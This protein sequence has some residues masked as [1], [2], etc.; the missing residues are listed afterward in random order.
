MTPVSMSY[1]HLAPAS[2]NSRLRAV[3][4]LDR[5]EENMDRMHG[6]LKPGTLMAAVIKADGYGHGAVPIGRLLDKKPYLW[7]FAVA[8]PEEAL[9]LKAAGITKPVMLLGY[10]FPESFEDLILND[11]RLTV[12]DEATAACLNETA[13]KMDRPCFIHIAVDTGMSRIGFPVGDALK[14]AS[15]DSVCRI[16]RMEGLKAE[17][18]F[19]HFARADE[20]DDEPALR[21]LTPFLSFVESLTGRGVSFPIVHASNSAAILKLKEANLDM[22]RAGIALYGLSPSDEVGIER[23]ALKPA[24]SL[25]SHVSYVKELPEGTPVSYGGTFVTDR[26]TLVATIPVGY[27]D[28]YPRLLS[29]KGCVL[30]RGQR[31]PILGRIC[32]DQFMVDVT[33]IPGAERGD[34]AVLLGEQGDERIFAEEIGALSGRFNYE[35]AC[36]ITKRVPRLYREGGEIIGQVDY[37]HAK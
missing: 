21:Q 32:M 29:N 17:G 30:I 4:D 28:G 2:P 12:F 33:G 34:E 8:T 1:D 27:A 13:L 15:L 14:E 36:D 16:V 24:M 11:I 37:F 25:I 18:I 5:I 23:L 7:G 35:L 6:N 3:I 10:A 26:K 9:E 22:V 19:T 20:E 31:A